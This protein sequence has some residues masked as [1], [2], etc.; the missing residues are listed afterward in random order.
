MAAHLFAEEINTKSDL[1]GCLF[2]GEIKLA[3]CKLIKKFRDEN[4]LY[5]KVQ[6]CKS[7]IKM[8]SLTQPHLH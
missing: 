8:Q 2:G 6:S 1:V 4:M 7:C 3:I 5:R